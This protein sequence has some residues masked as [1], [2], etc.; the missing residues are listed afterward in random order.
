M[1]KVPPGLQ[2]IDTMKLH[3]QQAEQQKEQQLGTPELFKDIKKKDD[4]RG[5]NL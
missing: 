3:G 1:Y 2:L 5:S 4:M